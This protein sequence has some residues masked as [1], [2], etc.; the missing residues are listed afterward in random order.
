MES[1]K[2]ILNNKNEKPRKQR[3]TLRQKEKPIDYDRYSTIFHGITEK[4]ELNTSS[5]LTVFA[6][7]EGLSRGNNFCVMNSEKLAFLSGCDVPELKALLEEFKVRGLIEEG[8]DSLKRN[9]WKLTQ[10]TRDLVDPIRRTLSYQ[11][12]RKYT[13]LRP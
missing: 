1:L 12:A 2:D 7:I 8:R 9:G 4:L 3:R 13:S 6:N 5:K 11:R 10:K